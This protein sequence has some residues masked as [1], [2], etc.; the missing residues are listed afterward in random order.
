MKAVRGAEI[1]LDSLHAISTPSGRSGA[2]S[3]SPTWT[4]CRLFTVFEALTQGVSIDHIHEITKIDKFFIHK[5]QNLVRFEE[6]LK[7]G[8][9]PETYLQGKKYGYPDKV[10]ARLAGA[11][12][13]SLPHRFPSYKMVD[14][15]AA[16][17]QAQTPYFYATYDDALRRPELPPQRAKDR[18]RPGV[19]P[20]PHRPGH[21]V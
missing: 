10:L 9:T 6:S 19:R 2:T 14:T 21:R 3:G 4:I 8:I 11:A 15:C 20:H 12:E 7:G 13:A 18:H 16:E 1:K 17:F 5:L